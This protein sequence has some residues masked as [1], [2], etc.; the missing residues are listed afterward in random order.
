VKK[1]IS[2]VKKGKKGD[3]HRTPLAIAKRN[4]KLVL[5]LKERKNNRKGKRG[6]SGVRGGVDYFSKKESVDWHVGMAKFLR[7][8]KRVA[9]RREK[10][11]KEPL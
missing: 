3:R 2:K 6:G 7:G 1:I 4:W 8:R 9:Q 11:K 5:Y 10:E